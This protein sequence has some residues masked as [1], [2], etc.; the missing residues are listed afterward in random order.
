M[1]GKS[2]WEAAA[3][4]TFEEAGVRGT[5]DPKPVGTFRH[6]KQVNVLGSFRG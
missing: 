6:A 4:E 1:P 5:V 2:L 3:Q